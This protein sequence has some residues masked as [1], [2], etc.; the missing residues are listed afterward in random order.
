MANDDSFPTMICA[1]N[2]LAYSRVPW[3]Y[4]ANG[5]TVTTTM[6]TEDFIAIPLTFYDVK[7]VS[8]T[9]VVSSNFS[10]S[11]A[12]TGAKIS[13]LASET[14]RSRQ[15]PSNTPPATVA[16]HRKD[17]DS[18]AIAGISV[19]VSIG[20]LVALAGMAVFW[21]RRR[22]VKRLDE[23]DEHDG[24]LPDETSAPIE[25]EANRT[26][27]EMDTETRTAELESERPIREM[28]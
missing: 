25:L 13:P 5:S 24:P 6:S 28:D 26:V 7:F 12:T 23:V 10:A 15:S 9:A 4:I 3:T 17:L 8:A 2:T 1:G 19:G 11:T 18:G 21:L 16:P 20:V 22:G 14:G 27:G